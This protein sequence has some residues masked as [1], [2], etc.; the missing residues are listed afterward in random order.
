MSLRVVFAGTPQFAVSALAAICAEH[1]VVGVLTQPDRPAGRGRAL[2]SSP[3]KEFA[4]ARHLP[5]AQPLT[6]R[7]EEETTLATLAQLRQWR[8]DVMVVV[9]YGLMLPQ[10]V[11][12]LPPLGCLNIHASLLPRWRGAAPIQR[13]ILAGDQHTG[14]TIMQM[15]AGLDTGPILLSEAV[16]IR[17]DVIA[18]ELQEE[19]ASLGARLVLRALAALEAGRLKPQ[20]QPAAGATYAQKLSTAEAAIDWR[21]SATT[22]DRQIRALNPWPAARALYNGESVKLLRSRVLQGI[23]PATA[24]P[25]TLLG[26]RDGFLAVA[27]GEGLLGVAELQRAGRRKVSAQDFVNAEQLASEPVARAFE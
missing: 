26:L 27:C 24:G 16:P 10:T 12:D 19:L 1:T 23:A 3:V 7:G 2:T 22:I 15:D 21:S 5:L 9:A 17:A 11:L 4:L 14:I 18:S 25:G 6:L 13:A 20:P 8:P